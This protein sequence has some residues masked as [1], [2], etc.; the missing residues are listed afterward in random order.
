MTPGPTAKH[1]LVGAL[2]L[3]SGP[4]HH[5]LGPR[6]TKVLFWELLQR[7]DDAYPATHYQRV[8]VVDTYKIHQAKAVG[9]WLATHP[10]FELLLLL[11]MVPRANPIERAVG[12]VHDLCTRNHTR[13]RVLDLVADVVEHL[14]VN[15]PWPYKLPD[16]YDDPAVTAAVENMTMEQ[17]LAA[18]G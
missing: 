17:T 11:T 10:R 8:D 12:D 15:G 7:P 6:T 4:L 2:E 18:A 3:A 16:I 13:Q 9:Q 14:D 5:C 1:S